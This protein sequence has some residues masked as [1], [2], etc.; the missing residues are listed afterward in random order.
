MKAGR[1]ALTI[2]RFDDAIKHF[3][4]AAQ[5]RPGDEQAAA[6]LRKAQQGREDALADAARKQDAQKEAEF[7]RLM[8]QGRTAMQAK[9]YDDA[10]KLFSQAV[11]LDPKD[12]GAARALEDA[13]EE[14]KGKAGKQAEYNKHIQAGANLEQQ[15]RF[16]EAVK[17]YQE[18][19][20]LAPGDVQAQTGIRRAEFAH[21]MG[22]GRR[23]LNGKRFNEAERAF[24]EALQRVPGHPEAMKGLQTARQ[25]KK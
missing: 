1:D 7:K 2:R 8:T 4:R 10:V 20:R 22:E 5:I 3:A 15:Q 12:A 24:L 14:L 25:G 17:S 11:K 18:A 6:L 23:A 9:R 21:F 19:L 16:Q 13:R